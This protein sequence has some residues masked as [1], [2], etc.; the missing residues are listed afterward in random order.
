MNNSQTEIVKT[1]HQKTSHTYASVR[2]GGHFL[3]W[4]RMPSPFKTYRGVRRIGLPQ[5][6]ERPEISAFEALAPVTSEPAE[7]T[8][9]HLDGIARLLFF[10]AGITK[11]KRYSD[12]SEVLFRAASCTGALYEI[13][14]Y[15]VCGRLPDLEA[16]VYH[17]DPLTF[18]LDVLRI[19]D[20]RGLL[21]DATEGEPDCLH[22]PLFLISTGIYWRNAWK[23][24][25]RTYR[26]FGWDNGTI[27]ANLLAVCRSLRWPASVVL[28][29]R[30]E[31]VNELLGIDTE[32]EVS[33]ALVPIGKGDSG[34][35]RPAVDRLPFDADP[36]FRSSVDFPIM[37]TTHAATRLRSG[38]EVRAWRSVGWTKH[39]A[40]VVDSIPLPD[41]HEV[42]G[43]RPIDRTILNRGSSRQ[44]NRQPISFQDFAAVV[45]G[46]AQ[47]VPADFLSSSRDLL[48]DWYILVHA[49]DG[50]A[51]GAY[52]LSRRE[53]RLELLK[54]G[55]FRSEGAFLALEQSLGGDGA[56]DV[57]F[58]ADLNKILETF[59][60]RGYRAVQLEAGISGGRIY[61]AAY[62][63]RLGATG[64]T[65]YDD[66]VV[67]FFSPHA[68]GKS[69]I[70]LVAVGHSKQAGVKRDR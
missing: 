24:R 32:E 43:A 17:F 62:S 15:L 65:F 47:D 39:A 54:T 2:T 70:F 5:P 42:V 61:L 60:N 68:S 22:A 69:S 14:L 20:Y 38:A 33:L 45:R 46:A 36:G 3:D 50:V 52:V 23:Y 37:R 53:W 13:E 34:T 58:L 67:D 56:F 8:P 6:G 16:G 64:L 57:F 66:A 10:S 27:F 48:N 40:A 28:G 25:A 49:V 4:S 35:G 19:G 1:Y 41:F 21:A 12:G 9:I 29:Y 44:F 11:K 31:P 51:P 18:S 7:Q 30:D 55:S 59:G 26:H 63:L